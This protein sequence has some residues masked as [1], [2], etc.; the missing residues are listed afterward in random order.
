MFIPFLFLPHEYYFP[1]H[2]TF[3]SPSSLFFVEAAEV[4]TNFLPNRLILRYNE[5]DKNDKD[6]LEPRSLSKIQVTKQNRV[7]NKGLI[8]T[9]KT[10]SR[11]Q[12]S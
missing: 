10:M 9:F 2:I 8:P 12:S 3:L 11:R 5:E 1:S 7:L 6:E 4:N